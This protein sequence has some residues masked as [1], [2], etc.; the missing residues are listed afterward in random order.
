MPFLASE[1]KAVQIVRER[2][3]AALATRGVFARTARERSRG[4]LRTRSLPEGEALVL[5]PC[6]SVHML[7][8]YLDRDNR[9]VWEGAPVTVRTFRSQGA[10]G[11]RV[12]GPRG[13]RPGERRHNR[14]LRGGV[15]H[16]SRS[17]AP[18]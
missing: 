14:L 11:D 3:G 15:G 6:N 17:I 4:L 9:V 2:D 5:D 10:Q 18:Q 1:V 16:G 12:A 13:W 8:V 7:A